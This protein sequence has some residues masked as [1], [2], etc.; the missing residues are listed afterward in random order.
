MDNFNVPLVQFDKN[1]QLRS[2]GKGCDP[3]IAGTGKKVKKGGIGDSFPQNIKQPL[4]GLVGQGADIG[5]G[6]FYFSPFSRAG[7]YAHNLTASLASLK[8]ASS[9]T[10][11]ATRKFGEPDWR[12]PA[13]SPGP[14][15]FRSTSA[16]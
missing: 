12:M 2:A 5:L 9:F 14:R 10:I 3:N 4:F 6:S 11:S 1:R 15:S 16:M 8:I 13:T 7:D